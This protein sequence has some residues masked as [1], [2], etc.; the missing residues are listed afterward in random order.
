MTQHSN[1]L[2]TMIRSDAKKWWLPM[3]FMRPGMENFVGYE[4]SARLSELGKLYP[5]M[6]ESRRAGK[7]VE[8]RISWENMATFWPKIPAEFRAIFL[9]N[10]KGVMRTYE[11]VGGVM[12]EK[13]V[14][15]SQRV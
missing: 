9:K 5:D 4:A 15:N 12:R 1:I 14:V 6:I 8:R 11:E 2:A 7:F 10:G 3:D 13:L